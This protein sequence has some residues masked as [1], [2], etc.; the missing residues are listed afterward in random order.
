[1]PEP[2]RAPE[3]EPNREPAAKPEAEPR[4][5]VE[6]KKEGGVNWVELA[7]VVA[8]PLVTLLVGWFFNSSLNMRQAQDNNV[9]LYADM[10]GRRE[11]ADAA[12]RKDMFKS[13]LDTFLKKDP[14]QQPADFLET[15][16]LNIEL[17]AYNFHESLDL[18]PLFKHARRELLTAARD[19]PDGNMLWRLE[20]VAIDVKER[21][22]AV[23]AD[24]GAVEAGSID[25]KLA[26]E[27]DSKAI[28]FSKS[29]VEYRAE[30]HRSGPT[31]CLSLKSA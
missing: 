19:D 9:R 17:L 4:K 25:M 6:P 23:L 29:M 12:L 31:A 28:G 22:L 8:M 20:R 3:P 26:F 1:M 13:I 14:K 10:M 18:G 27:G 21:Q 5:A 15:E 24:K 2:A 30:E 16:V 11:E 7:K